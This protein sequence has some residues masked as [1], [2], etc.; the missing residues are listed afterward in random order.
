MFPNLAIFI[1]NDIF[2]AGHCRY[3]SQ[4]SKIPKYVLTVVSSEEHRRASN[5]SLEKFLVELL[6]KCRTKIS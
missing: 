1:Q 5:V 4:T 3:F 2:F 6:V